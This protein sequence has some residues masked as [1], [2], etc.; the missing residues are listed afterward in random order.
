MVL[1]ESQIRSQYVKVRMEFPE[2]RRN[3]WNQSSWEILRP[4]IRNKDFVS[5]LGENVFLLSGAK[6]LRQ[7][8]SWSFSDNWDE[9]RASLMVQRVKNLP[10]MQ[11]TQV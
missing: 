4:W 7:G 9:G 10:A 6:V 8:Y 2:K 1:L 3:S 5:H 11:E